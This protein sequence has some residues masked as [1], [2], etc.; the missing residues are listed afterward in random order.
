MSRAVKISI[1]LPL[2]VL[3]QADRERETTGESRSEFVRQAIEERIRRMAEA[4]RVESYVESY[5]RSPETAEEVASSFA[6][7]QAA[8][9]SE[10]W[11]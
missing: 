1:H 7:S 2:E 5:R 11:E 8:L 3:E 10:P 4:E 6:M 9:S